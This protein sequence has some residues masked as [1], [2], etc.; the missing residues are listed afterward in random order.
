MGPGSLHAPLACP[1]D[2]ARCIQTV[3]QVAR[4]R[5]AVSAAWPVVVDLCIG[6]KLRAMGLASKS[7]TTGMLPSAAACTSSLP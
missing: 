3:V 6:R 5:C 2:I 7:L 4:H 1:R